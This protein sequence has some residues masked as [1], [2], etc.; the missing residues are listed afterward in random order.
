MSSSALLR[1]SSHTYTQNRKKN[2][3][4]KQQQQ[5]KPCRKNKSS[6]FSDV[7]LLLQI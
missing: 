3:K 2:K 6:V 1:N 5:K 4:Q 7:F